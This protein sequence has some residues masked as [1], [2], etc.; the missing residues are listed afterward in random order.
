MFTNKREKILL[1]HEVIYLYIRNVS[2]MQV[3]E[4]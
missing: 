3:H 2:N 4:Y 1:I